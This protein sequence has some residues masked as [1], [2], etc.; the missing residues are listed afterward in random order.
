[1]NSSSH[2]D[3]FCTSVMPPSLCR[4]DRLP[5][6]ASNSAV[7][8]L[9]NSFPPRQNVT[10]G[11][12]WLSLYYKRQVYSQ[13][14]FLLLYYDHYQKNPIGVVLCSVRSECKYKVIIYR[15]KSII[16]CTHA[17]THA[18]RPTY[19]HTRRLW[20]PPQ[21]SEDGLSCWHCVKPPLTIWL[22]HSLTHSL[23]VICS[24]GWKFA[25]SERRAYLHLYQTGSG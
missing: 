23:T 19:T 1:M 25:N 18:R 6:A 3:T 9:A 15:N 13:H 11:N 10:A 21:S 17:H 24:K 4:P 2:V 12:S 22:S 5:A 20:C 16:T 14:N 8:N 7:A